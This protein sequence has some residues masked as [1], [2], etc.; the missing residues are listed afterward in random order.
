MW[1]DSLPLT[2]FSF[3]YGLKPR[4]LFVFKPDAP[5]TQMSPPFS[6]LPLEPSPNICSFALIPYHEMF[7]AVSQ[8][9]RITAPW[10]RP[11]FKQDSKA[12]LFLQD[13]L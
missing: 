12:I 5:Q 7:N 11:H 4:L 6:P 2:T 3:F 8:P 1:V 9:T 10:N 13:A